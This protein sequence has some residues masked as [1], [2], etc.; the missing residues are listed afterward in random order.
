MA[1]TKLFAEILDSTIWQETNETRIV[2]ITLLAMANK[3]GEVLASIPG[4]ARRAGVTLADAETAL[5]AL[6]SPDPYSRTPDFEG[7]R[8]EKVEGGYFL[9][10]YA[11][12]R[13]KMNEEE[14]REYLRVKQ[15]ERRERLKRAGTSTPV[16]NG[17]PPSTKSTQAEGEAEAEAEAGEKAKRSDRNPTSGSRKNGKVEFP[18]TL[19]RFWEAYPRAGRIRSSRKKVLVEW[20][21]LADVDPDFFLESLRLWNDSPEWQK[22]EGKF[23]LAADRYIRERKFDDPPEE[24]TG[25]KTDAKGRITGSHDSNFDDLIK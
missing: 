9:L 23:V 4:L 24:R 5:T 8:I 13:K 19:E 14:R 7:R 22:D 2:W 21:K 6:Q 11:K 25:D 1:F 18:E 20:K 17:Q 16:N 3:D 12:Y 10:N 15:A